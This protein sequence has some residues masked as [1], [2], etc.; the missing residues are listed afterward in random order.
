MSLFKT[1][2]WWR[3]QCGVNESFDRRSLLVA[4]LFGADRKDIVIVGS[5]SGCLR[6]YS[7]LSQWIDETKLPSGYKSTDLIIETQIGDCIVDMKTGK[8]VS[9]S[10]DTRLAILTSTK[11]IIYSIVLNQGSVEY[12]L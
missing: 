11:L 3:T 7:P 6:I 4:P 2:E 12:G 5:H 1:K 10:Q 9:G 8:F